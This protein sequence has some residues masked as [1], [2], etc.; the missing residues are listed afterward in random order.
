MI[1]L[2][3]LD[4]RRLAVQAPFIAV[5]LAFGLLPIFFNQGETIAIAF[6]AMAGVVVIIRLFPFDDAA[7]NYTL[8]STL[9]VSRRQAITARF[10]LGIV[11]VAVDAALLWLAVLGTGT[12]EA[13]LAAG[14]LAAVLLLNLAITAPM[15][16]RGGLGTLGPVAPMLVFALLMAGVFWLPESWR[17]ALLRF[18]VE[19][20]T[21]TT[22]LAAG[23]LLGLLV[24]SY[25][26]S[27]RWFER[28]DF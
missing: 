25:L 14:L 22:G 26:L 15:A 27:V 21:A 6:L 8:I 13:L 4:L 2:F 28:R 10:M 12:A 9:P 1:A 17:I 19:Q 11:I 24:A 5:F 20:P 3:A 7:R 16:S 23:L 18:A